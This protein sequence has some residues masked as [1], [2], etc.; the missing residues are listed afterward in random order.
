LNARETADPPIDLGRTL[1][2]GAWTS[3]QKWIL[4]LA[5]LAFCADGLANQVLGVAMPA[6]I[7]EWGVRREVFAPVAAVGLIGVALGTVVGGI[8]GDRFGR[9][10]G[11]IGAMALFGLMTVIASRVDG[12][13]SLGAVRFLDGLGI[14]AAI[15]NGA[16][17]IS[18]F[19][20]FRRRSV[21]IAVSMLFIPVG[22]LLA[23]AFGAL[24]LPHAGWRSL[25]LVTGLA[26]LAVAVLFVVA[27]PESP[28]FLL[29]WPRRRPELIKLL[30]RV[31]HGFSSDATFVDEAARVP[32]AALTALFGAGVR[33][34]TAGLWGAFFCCLLASYTLFSWLPS[35]LAAQGLDLKATS[36]AM[37]SF[38]FGG[39]VGGVLTGWLI[40]RLGSRVSVLA[41]CALAAL[42]ALAMGFFTFSHANLGLLAAILGAEGLVIGGVHTGLYTLAA[43]AY[44]PF[45]RATGVGSASAF[46]RIGAIA[47]SFTGVISLEIAGSK[48]FFVLIAVWMLLSFVGVLVLQRHVLAVS[49]RPG[50][51]PQA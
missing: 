15:P 43:M 27:L 10:W 28:R 6:L 13:V 23:G 4:L 40:Q 48:G 37:T 50:A 21:A 24:I 17:L 41:M 30:G 12:V 36:L 46:G 2:E 44:P 47:S 45:I 8:L 33:R 19:T 26:T 16:A 38:N 35:M 49:A 9:R 5:A 51:L 1:D 11:L 29:R 31:G 7:S 14:G 20:P 32:R 39:M 3:F 18:E 42:G 22:G 25:F 34:D